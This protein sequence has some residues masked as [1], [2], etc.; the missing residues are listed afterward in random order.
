MIPSSLA[1]LGKNCEWTQY[2][3]NGPDYDS[4]EKF[5]ARCSSFA[6]RLQAVRKYVHHSHDKIR[7]QWPGLHQLWRLHSVLHHITGMRGGNHCSGKERRGKNLSQSHFTP[8]FASFFSLSPSLLDAAYWLCGF[9]LLAT[10]T[11]VENSLP[12]PCQ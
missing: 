8:Y 3:I 10:N 5:A 7:S 6:C 9:I 2:N 12:A 1:S 4:F 11:V